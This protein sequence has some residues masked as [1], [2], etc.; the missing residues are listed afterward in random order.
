MHKNE[1]VWIRENQVQEIQEI[2]GKKGDN[3]WRKLPRPE[4]MNR[5]ALHDSSWARISNNL[6]LHTNYMINVHLKKKKKEWSYACEFMGTISCRPKSD[7]G[8]NSTSIV[9][10]FI[11]KIRDKLLDP[12]VYINSDWILANKN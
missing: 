4:S 3:N 5:A 12:T 10:T 11:V 2:T 8:A 9:E 1:K 7:M 6:K